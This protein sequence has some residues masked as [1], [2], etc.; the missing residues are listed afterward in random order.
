MQFPQISAGSESGNNIAG[1]VAD[2]NKHS[3]FP[4][5]KLNQ[6]DTRA[7][8][9]TEL[10]NKSLLVLTP[11]A[12]LCAACGIAVSFALPLLAQRGC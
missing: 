5:Q 1:S 10:A 2:A 8:N 11:E 3:H 7:L 6:A 4:G 12:A 9:P